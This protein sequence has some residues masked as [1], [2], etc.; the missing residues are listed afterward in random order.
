MFQTIQTINFLW[1][2]DPGN[3]SVS[4]IAE[5]SPVYC[6]LGLTVYAFLWTNFCPRIFGDVKVWTKWDG[7]NGG[8]QGSSFAGGRLHSSSNDAPHKLHLQIILTVSMLIMT[9]NGEDGHDDHQNENKKAAMMVILILIWIKML[10]RERGYAYR[11]WPI[12]DGWRLR[13]FLWSEPELKFWS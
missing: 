4:F 2:Y 5:L 9:I 13:W 10:V 7:D 11:Q 1:G 12:V 3:M 6:C 8:H